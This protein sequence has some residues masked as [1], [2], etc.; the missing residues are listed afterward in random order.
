MCSNDFG[1]AGQTTPLS[2]TTTSGFGSVSGTNNVLVESSTIS[3]S[4]GIFVP[5][6]RPWPSMN[7]LAPSPAKTQ[8]TPMFGG[9]FHKSTSSNKLAS[10]DNATKSGSLL[11]EALTAPFTFSGLDNV[12]E[13]SLK[14]AFGNGAINKKS[15]LP[16]GMAATQ[17]HNKPK[18]PSSAS[19][20]LFPVTSFSATQTSKLQPAGEGAFSHVFDVTAQGQGGIKAKDIKGKAVDKK[21]KSSPTAD[22]TTLVIRKIPEMFNKNVWIK[23]FYS[24]FG[25]VT[26]VVC[27][28]ARKSATVTFK[29][30][31]SM[32]HTNAD[33]NKNNNDDDDFTASP[34]PFY[35]TC[36]HEEKKKCFDHNNAVYG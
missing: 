2:S 10:S 34:R 12:S 5:P 22:L 4:N 16:F 13:I 26:K 1:S 32:L 21:A 23:R 6:A 15:P 36:F 27:I 7:S 24:R 3:P 28:A 29:T 11:R 14:G 20:P 35:C 30:H 17:P 9:S 8:A 19:Q 18:H 33:D 25:E 31:V